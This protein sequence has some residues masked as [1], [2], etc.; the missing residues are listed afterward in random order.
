MGTV[1]VVIASLKGVAIH[2]EPISEQHPRTRLSRRDGLPRPSRWSLLAMTECVR[3]HREP[4]RRGDPLALDNRPEL[5]LLP[6]HRE[7]VARG[8]PL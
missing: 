7:G 3:C 1:L 8:D 5:S 4:E 6:C 2:C